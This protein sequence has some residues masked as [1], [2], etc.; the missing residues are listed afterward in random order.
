LRHLLGVGTLSCAALLASACDINKVVANTTGGLLHQA[1]P[2][3]DALSDYELAGQGLPGVIIQLEAF[4]S[5]TPENELLALDLAKAYLGY[6]QGWV[7]NEYEVAFA[8][9][10]MD[11]AEECR[12]RARNLYLRARDLAI[13]AMRVRDDGVDEALTSGEEKLAEYLRD[14]YTAKDDAPP[15]FW[16]G[17]A[18]G[19]AINLSLDDPSLIVDLPVAKL[20][21]Q[22]S[23]ELDEL[24]FNGGAYLFLATAE[25]ALPAAMGGK[26]ELARELFERGLERTGRKNQLMLV[27]YARFWAVNNQQRELFRKLLT[28]VVEAPDLGPRVRLINKVALVRAKRYLEQEAT[29]F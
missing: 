23:L 10:D 7:E 11:R 21:V 19:A 20:L 24:F 29:L 28:E 8:K 25:A 15:V 2:S 27:H 13:N 16:A 5:V 1:A 18:W 6:A 3:I 4:Y 12:A 14:V 26:P 17:M 22:R 9:G